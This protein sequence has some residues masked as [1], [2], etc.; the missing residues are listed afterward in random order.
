M[1]R[2]AMLARLF[3]A[4]ANPVRVEIVEALRE[5]PRCVCELVPKLGVEQPAVSKHL[6]A[7]R[8]EGLIASEK[9]GQR[10]VYRLVGGYAGE[11]VDLAETFL[12][13]R[14]SQEGTVWNSEPSGGAKKARPDRAQG[15]ER[16]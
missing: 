10:V 16:T 7:L 12:R 2:R 15:G 13:Q 8:S 9:D 1:D 3:R 11:L 5:G 4:L 14:W 6:A